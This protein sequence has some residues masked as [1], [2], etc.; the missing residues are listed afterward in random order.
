[1]KNTRIFKCCVLISFAILVLIIFCANLHKHS[2]DISNLEIENDLE[3]W[4][5]LNFNE[6]VEL[7]LEL[8]ESNNYLIAEENLGNLEK[9]IMSE[10]GNAVQ[11][12]QFLGSFFIKG[13]EEVRGTLSTLVI[14]VDAD[15]PYIYTVRDPLSKVW[16]EH[17]DITWTQLNSYNTIGVNKISVRL[18]AAGYISTS[19]KN[20]R[21]QELLSNTLYPTF[22]VSIQ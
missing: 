22:S 8:S 15:T 7:D 9:Q 14:I 19:T 12:Y 20:V 10:T 3:C 4:K 5:Q 2:W 16:C 1:M 6:A 21:N 13:Y 17:N 18:G 11:Y